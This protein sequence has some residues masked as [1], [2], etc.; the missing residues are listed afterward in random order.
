[1]ELKSITSMYS[2][3]ANYKLQMIP[4]PHLM[5]FTEVIR[6]QVKLS[7]LTA[8]SRMERPF[9]CITRIIA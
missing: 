7:T 1:M 5:T 9:S 8:L 4:K 2:K 6:Y 3:T